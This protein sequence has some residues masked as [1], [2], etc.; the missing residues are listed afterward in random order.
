[1]QSNVSRY[2]IELHIQ[3]LIDKLLLADYPINSDFI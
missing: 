2:R 3:N 1:M